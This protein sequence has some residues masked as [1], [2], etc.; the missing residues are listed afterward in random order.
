MSS[1]RDR[2]ASRLQG[3]YAGRVEKGEFGNTTVTPFD[4]PPFAKDGDHDVVAEGAK[5]WRHPAVAVA[6]VWRPSSDRAGPV[7]EVLKE[8]S[9]ANLQFQ[10]SNRLTTLFEDYFVAVG[11]PLYFRVNEDIPNLPAWQD[12]ED[13]YRGKPDIG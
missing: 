6:D 3:P 8:A 9:E 13:N 10:W 11:L 12:S 4:E 1:A 7:N 5:F 2:F